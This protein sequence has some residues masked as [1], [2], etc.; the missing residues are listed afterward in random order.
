MSNLENPE[1]VDDLARVAREAKIS[2]TEE[3]LEN[4]TP[5]QAGQITVR[6][7]RIAATREGGDPAKVVPTPAT[8]REAAIALD[9]WK[10]NGKAGSAWKVTRVVKSDTAPAVQW[11]DRSNVTGSL[12]KVQFSC[13]SRDTRRQATTRA[14]IA[15]FDAKADRLSKKRADLAANLPGGRLWKKA[16]SRAQKEACKSRAKAIRKQIERGQY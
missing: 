2:T 8:I 14:A 9:T 4:L 10:R 11:A 1:F 15:S 7:D 13:S 16:T 12:I 5:E 3:K 6:A